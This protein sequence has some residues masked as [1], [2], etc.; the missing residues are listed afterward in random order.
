M[1]SRICLLNAGAT[2]TEA[3][4]NLVLPGCGHVTVVDAA[5]VSECDLASNFFVERAR[6][7]QPRAQAALELLLELND[8]VKGAWRQADPAALAASEPA[9]FA[10]FSLVVATQ[11]ADAALLPLA[12]LL[13]AARVPLIVARSYGLLGYYRAV[14]P[15]HTV[16]ESKPDAQTED[17]RIAHPFPALRAYVD[18]IDLAGLDDMTHGHVPYVALLAKAVDA[19]RAQQQQAQPSGA[20]AGAAAGGGGGGGVPR[21]LA[22]K[23]AF[24][25]LVRRMAR[26]PHEAN[27]SEALEHVH[28]AYAGAGQGGGGG[29]GSAAAASSSSAGSGAGVAAATV[30]A[31]LASADPGLAAVLSDAS[32]AQL[33]PTSA[34]FWFV[35]RALR[36]F[37]ADTGALPVSGALPDMTATTE[38]YLALQRVYAAQAAEDAA[39][40]AARVRALEA[41]VGAPAGHVSAELVALM[42]RHARSLRVVRFRP[43]ADELRPA[44]GGAGDPAVTAAFRDEFDSA[45]ALCGVPAPA[46]APAGWYWQLRAAQR[47]A[48]EH[49]RFPGVLPPAGGDGGAADAPHALAADA[50]QLHATVLQ[51][52]AEHGLSHEDAAGVVTPEQAVETCVARRAGAGLSGAAVACRAT[53]DTTHTYRSQ[54]DCTPPPPLCSVR[55]G[56]GELHAVAALVGAIVA[57]EAVKLLTHQYLPLN[58]TYVWVGVAGV[59][60]SL[61]A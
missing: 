27:F 55:Y 26:A 19:W 51:L 44:G 58:N 32:A 53:T 16:V 47:F 37:V 48:A 38:L 7:G 5:V 10:Q 18:G 41:G 36:E 42:C 13:Y 43:L 49:G 46:M 60:G 40:I 33:A 35:V 11:M 23:A 31:Y 45:R 61:L 57:Q 1:E 14:V 17:L 34:P 4:K 6:L 54:P 30:D 8:D 29:G 39:S 52:L 59:G 50:A 3:L 28:H 21:S 24:K 25:G 12:D 22:D 20:G 9:F 15:E 56:A 2:G